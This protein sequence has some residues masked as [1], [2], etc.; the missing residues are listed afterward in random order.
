MKYLTILAAII[1][2]TL[3]LTACSSPTPTTTTW[4][5]VPAQPIEVV[6]VTGPMTPVNPGG[7]NVKI[8]LKNNGGEPVVQLKAV[9]K[10]ERDYEFVFDVSATAPLAAG[11]SI[12]L[13]Q[14]LI[15]AG[16]D[17]ETTYTLEITAT[18]QSG[19]VFTYNVQL[20]IGTPPPVK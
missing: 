19:A 17:S 18:N 5:S 12:S 7:P 3:G 15:G 8:T 11:Q 16:I 1:I 9:L 10:L 14:T 20:N 13:Q 4:H 6:A 2:L